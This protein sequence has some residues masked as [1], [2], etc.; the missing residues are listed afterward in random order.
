MPHRTIAALALAVA[1]AAFAQI[2]PPTGPVADSG[3]SLAE[4]A[5][6][7]TPIVINQQN[8]PGD[9]ANDF[10]IREPGR[11]VV[12]RELVFS[13]S[14][15]GI[16]VRPD[17]NILDGIVEIDLNGQRVVGAAGAR[18]VIEVSSNSFQRPNQ[19]QRV[20]IRDG[21]ILGNNLSTASQGVEAD[22]ETSLMLRNLVFSGMLGN[23]VSVGDG[24]II[25]H[26]QFRDVRLNAIRADSDGGNGVAVRDCFFERIGNAAVFL[27]NNARVERCVIRNADAEGVSTGIIADNGAIV[28]DCILEN[29]GQNA[30]LLGTDGLVSGCTIRAIGGRDGATIN[31]VTIGRSGRISDTIISDYQGTQAALFIDQNATAE[32]VTIDGSENGGIRTG[33]FSSTIRECHIDETA[34]L[35]IL[36][37][38]YC[39]IVDN[40]IEVRFTF[41][42][43]LEAEGFNEIDGNR[44]F[45][46][47]QVTGGGNRITR[48]QIADGGIVETNPAPS[49][50]NL[51]GPANDLTSPWANFI[52]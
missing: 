40:V 48:N 38:S 32:R 51:I 19:T 13:R 47:I 44:L 6:A 52:R 33:L 18:N 45:G 43:A 28:R 49:P 29:I 24:A 9:G 36:A 12:D 26:C 39:T 31:G 4:L 27:N 23:A 17:D 34:G 21:E 14:N 22:R 5:D 16:L 7:T 37:T 2:Q 46:T 1:S 11:Y 10:I 41:F 25:E 3:P 20:V 15:A 42:T 8:T 35:P 50:A 30:I